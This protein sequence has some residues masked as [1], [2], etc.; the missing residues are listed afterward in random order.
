MNIHTTAHG[1]L[2][3]SPVEVRHERGGADEPLAAP[4]R[5]ATTGTMKRHAVP[6]AQVAI[7]RG[8]ALLWSVCAGASR[9]GPVRTGANHLANPQDRF[10]VASATKFV[11]ACATLSLVEKGDLPL[12][13]PVA[14]WL[15]ELPQSDRLTL[16]M[17][18]S[19]RS[20]LREYFDDELIREKLKTDPSAEWRRA[21]L[22]EAGA[23]LGSE[24]APDQRFAYRNINYIAVGEMV[25][26]CTGRTVE[27]VVQERLSE[28]LGLETLSFC[29]TGHGHGRLVS[30]HKRRFGRAIDLL[31]RTNATLPS[32]TIGEVWTDGGIATSARDLATLTEAVFEGRL[33]DPAT[34]D[35]M[36]RRSASPGSAVGGVLGA[37]QSLYVGRARRSYGL[38]VAIEERSE[39]TT[40]GH[41]GMYYGWSA[42]TTFDP[43]TRVTIA[44][45]TNLAAIPVPAERLERALREVVRRAAAGR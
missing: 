28:P 16:R 15:P 3:P 6:E 27:D 7:R 23:R 43:Q 18:L 39:A 11:V 41:E 19:H 30:P 21:E 1:L 8:G 37:L 29:G 12:D 26:R 33:L 9:G 32:H 4:L 38:G 13:E 20:G 22:L 40:F 10:V 14:R 34:V 2:R 45:V 24:G 42:V 35:D 25:A 44:V 17:L 36:T 31:P 5:A